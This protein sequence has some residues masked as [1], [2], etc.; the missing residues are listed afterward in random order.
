MK[1]NLLTRDKWHGGQL[2]AFSAVDGLTDFENGLVARSAFDKPALEIKVPGACRIEFK[3]DSEGSFTLASDWMEIRGKTASV[4]CVMIDAFHLLI[5]GPVRFGET[6]NGISVLSQDN[7]HL[8]GSASRFNPEWIY[9]DMDAVLAE[10]KTWLDQQPLPKTLNPDSTQPL[11]KALSIMK[12][13]V[14]SA[15]GIIN[16][17]WSTPDRWPHRNMWLWDSVFHAAGW[18]HIDVDLSREM[19]NAVLDTQRQ[20]GFIAHMMTP[21]G[22]SRIIQ[23]PVLAMGVNLVNEIAPDREW[24]KSVYSKLSAYVNWDCDHRDSD[25]NRL[26]EWNI[27]GN[28]QCRSGESGM[29]NSPRFDSAIQLDAVDFNSFIAV[30]FEILSEFALQL[31]LEAESA[32]WKDR[33]ND[34]CQRI[35][36][37]WS[38]EVEF[39]MDRDVKRNAPSPALASS[40]FMPLIC[41]AAAPRQAD[42]LARHLRD[43]QIFGTAFPVPSIAAKDTEHYSEDMW[44]GPTWININWLIA[45][46]FERYERTDI[47]REIREKSIREIEKYWKKFSTFFEYY[48]DR[49]E[50][51][52]P[53]LK[54]KGECAPE[55][56]PYHQVL[57]DYGWSAALYVDMIFT[58]GG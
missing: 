36:G 12:S 31:G 27:E 38:A 13:Q 10:R 42:A 52:P 53:L 21:N 34:M 28:P 18:R 19:I 1:R 22:I 51:D 55:K 58:Q 15:E 4:T 9:A 23:P 8:I 6:G 48:H 11:A 50:L 57:H 29:D 40:G 35:R 47:A 49:S 33:Y 32:Q 45:R 2:F 3:A 14:C 5:K 17:T 44:R 25:G 46:G 54:R 24:I 26:L 20:D 56:H 16:H 43:P 30:E 41:G 7:R 37:L 39:F